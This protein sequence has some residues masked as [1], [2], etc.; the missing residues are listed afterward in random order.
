MRQFDVFRN[1]S[2]NSAK[3]APLVL[4]L[5]SSLT[6]T[7]TTVIVAPLVLPDRLPATSK[8]FPHLKVGARHLVLSTSELSAI[9]RH[10]L[11]HRSGN[12]ERHRDDIIAALD[13]LF[14]GF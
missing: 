7:E 6:I 1:P 5:Q 8:L 9:G 14:L 12:L 13:M 4:V 10:H 3:H 2:K 11:R